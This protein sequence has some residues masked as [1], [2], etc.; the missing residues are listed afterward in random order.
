MSPLFLI[1]ARGGSKGLPGKNI[2]ILGDKPLIQYSIEIARSLATDPH[3][4]VSTD[5]ST[6][7]GVVENLGLKVPFVR[8]PELATDS[9]SSR[10]VILH[11]LNFYKT[12]GIVYDT[13]VLLQPTSPFRTKKDVSQMIDMFSEEVDMIVSVKE[14]HHNPYFSLFEENNEGFLKLSKE[15]KFVRRQD[16]PTVFAY[17]GS[18]YVINANSLKRQ[19]FSE[20]SRVK[21]YLMNDIYSIDIDTPFDWLI[22]ETVLRNNLLTPF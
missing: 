12:K 7:I 3:I 16:C 13:V 17:N 2:R 14:S 21:K 20:F 6:I 15:G 5:D 9:A 10:D 1:T 22:A 4:C 18:V 8:P 19:I 11:A